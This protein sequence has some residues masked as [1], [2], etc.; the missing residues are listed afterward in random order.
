MAPKTPNPSPNSTAQMW[1]DNGFAPKAATALKSISDALGGRSKTVKGR[2]EGTPGSGG[3]PMSE[4]EKNIIK[5]L[6]VLPTAAGFTDRW[7]PDGLTA[8]DNE[9]LKTIGGVEAIPQ[10]PGF[11]EALQYE[12]DHDFQRYQRLQTSLKTLGL[13]NPLDDQSVINGGGKAKPSNVPAGK[14]SMTLLGAGTP[15]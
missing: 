3:G 1:Q 6:S 8:H 12:A 14:V 10:L 11:T 9:F 7:N 15:E 2:R 13:P 4:A 5:A